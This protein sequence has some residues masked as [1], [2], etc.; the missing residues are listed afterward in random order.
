MMDV[1]RVRRLGVINERNRQ[2]ACQRL[3]QETVK[4]FVQMRRFVSTCSRN[5]QVDIMRKIFD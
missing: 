2:I 4:R 3:A 1:K 5:E